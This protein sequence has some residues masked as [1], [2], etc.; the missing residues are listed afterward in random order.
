[1]KD[2]YRVWCCSYSFR[3]RFECVCGCAF[4][5]V[6]FDGFGLALSRLL[7]RAHNLLDYESS[8][9]LMRKHRVRVEGYIVD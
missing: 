2:W 6:L 8:R 7:T 5:C 9:R 1:M 3:I 4:E